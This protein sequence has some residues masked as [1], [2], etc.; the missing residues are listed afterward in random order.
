[1]HLDSVSPVFVYDGI[2]E[3]SISPVGGEVVAAQTLV[4]LHHPLGP[5][6]QLL[7]GRHVVRL[8][9][10]L[11]VGN[12]REETVQRVS[13]ISCKQSSLQ[14]FLRSRCTFFFGKVWADNLSQHPAG[15]F[16]L[17]MRFF[18]IYIGQ[19]LAKIQV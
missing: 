9:V 12:L 10:H 3:L 11:N 17:C 13:D 18:I 4:S 14:S 7:F 5:K 15:K 1:M 16:G 6:Q 19:M 2:E 8:A